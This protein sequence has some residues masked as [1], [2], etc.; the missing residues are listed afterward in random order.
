MLARY[1]L[2]AGAL[3]LVVFV[4]PLALLR[5]CADGVS[6]AAV[7]SRIAQGM[8]DAGTVKVAIASYYAETG[9]M[10]TDLED[11]EL[12]REMLRG[13]DGRTT[14]RLEDEGVIVVSVLDRR[15]GVRAV[16]YLEPVGDE[17]ESMRYSCKTGDLE[18]V[19]RFFP[20]CRYDRALATR[21]R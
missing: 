20:Q 7:R 3:I 6:G 11:M 12:T 21:S 14:I 19:E 2:I 10:P 15:G 4:V 18:D 13:A 5:G 9:E 16:M 8:A 17:P 1:S